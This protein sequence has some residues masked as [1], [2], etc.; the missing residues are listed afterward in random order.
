MG[1][2]QACLFSES[3]NVR[4]VWGV[5]GKCNL[6][7][8][9][10][11]VPTLKENYKNP[12]IEKY[13]PVLKDMKSSGVDTIYVSG[14]EPLLWEDIFEF[15]KLAKKN[16][17]TVTLG[18]HGAGLTKRKIK[19]LSEA[20]ID[21]VFVSLDSPKEEIHNFFRGGKVF[22]KTIAGLEELADSD[23]YTRI[24]SILWKENYKHLEEFV[25]FCKN[26][27]SEEIT[28][29]WP[30]K[31]G[32]A[33]KNPNILP[34]AEK[35]LDI[36]KELKFLKG[37]Y[38]DEI[39]ISYHRFE[40]FGPGCKR[41]GGGEKIFYLDWK[42]RLSPCFWVSAVEPEFFTSGSVFK[43]KFSS[44][45]KDETIKKFINIKEEREKTFGPGCPAICKIYNED[46]YSKDPL[47][48]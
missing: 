32:K 7:C 21:K 12:K 10:C 29:A 4:F 26:K 24:D 31:V 33:A 13:E 30:V 1:K 5:Y 15:I 20:N 22:K 38:S 9:H 37:K 17:I 28:F 8:R 39:K 25:N 16:E 41:C 46:F 47:F 2:N 23:I 3:P 11:A 19:R 35:Y 43:E 42:G 6:N 18:T 44:L 36:G 45:K 27:G 40:N 34:P 48:K 14:G